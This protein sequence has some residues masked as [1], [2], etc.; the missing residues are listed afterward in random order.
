MTKPK[1]N[2]APRAPGA[3]ALQS[4]DGAQD[5]KPTPKPAKTRKSGRD[6]P[7]TFT[8]AL[9]AEICS[10]LIAGERLD[11]ICA[12]PHMPKSRETI[13]RWRKANPDFNA[14]YLE[15]RAD[16]ADGIADEILEIAETE[17]DIAR[18]R[19][20][21][22]ARRV[23]LHRLHRT[24]PEAASPPQQQP[25]SIAEAL[26]ANRKK[27]E[28]LVAEV[29]HERAERMRE[30]EAIEKAR[31]PDPRLGEKLNRANQR[32]ALHVLEQR[33]KDLLL[34]EGLPASDKPI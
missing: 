11:E 8:E 13:W 34:L 12:S 27:I 28:A 17:N 10:R 22:E 31:S 5:G 25:V 15:A 33:K 1:K 29:G 16:Q 2:R 9:G 4:Q 21:I 14:N 32:Y 26:E 3:P 18:A 23:V 19:L 7:S 24:Y 30:D 20:K 6:R